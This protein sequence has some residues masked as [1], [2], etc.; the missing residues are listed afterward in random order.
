MMKCVKIAKAKSL[1]MSELLQPESKNGSVII[2]VHSCGICGSDIHYW[3]T[4]EPRDLVLGHE[5][6]GEVVNPGSRSDL[7]VGDR[8][9]GLP[10]SPCGMCK[11][12]KSGNPQYCRETW[13][14]AVGLSMTNPGGFAE[15][16]SCRADMVKAIPTSMSYDE[17]TLVEPS[18]VA[19]HAV[20]LAQIKI[21][22]KVLV[23]GGGIIGLMACEFAKLAGAGYIAMLETNEARAQ[24]A[25]DEGV[26]NVCFDA[27]K[28]DVIKELGEV[29]GG[30]FDVVIECCGN[31]AAV[32]EAL[33]AVAPGGKIVLV[34]VAMGPIIIPTVMAVMGEVSMIGAIA[35]TEEEFETCIDLIARKVVRPEKY[36]DDVVP[37]DKVQA[38]F[39][40]LTNGQDRAV[41]IIVHPNE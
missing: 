16:T 1:E 12:C 34:G 24:R 38:S 11:A 40:R 14:E 30:G 18:A 4:G 37:L 21:G 7:K 10:I 5:F 39:E 17:G 25:V 19:L 23:V 26:A 31:S 27:K 8:V 32:S 29:T 6:C 22:A 3:D 41:K 20:G 35:Y 9:T 2:K 33:M 36:I 15:Y 13:N 28:K